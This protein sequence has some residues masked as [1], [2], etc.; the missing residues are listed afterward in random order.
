[1]DTAWERLLQVG[2]LAGVEFDRGRAVVEVVIEE[3]GAEA[4]VLGERR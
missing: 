4:L 3:R 1:M 2:W